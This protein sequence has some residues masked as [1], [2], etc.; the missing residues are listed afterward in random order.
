MNEQILREFSELTPDRILDCIEKTIQRPMTGLTYPMP[1]Y[2]NR[3][4]E[5]QTRAGERIIAKFYRPGRWASAAI[6]DEHRFVLD[7][8]AAEIPVV[9][10]MTFPDGATLAEMDGFRFAVFPK[11]SGREF[12]VKED[13]DWVRIGRLVARLHLAGSLRKAETRIRLHPEF[14]MVADVAYLMES[15]AVAP[16]HLSAFKEVADRLLKLSEAGFKSVESIRIHGD[17]HRA[18]LLE[19]PGEG[20]MVI[21]FDDMAMGPP[22]QDIWLLLP[23]HA[24]HCGREIDLI[25]SGYTQ[26]RDFDRSTLGL[27]EVLRAMRIIYYLAWCGRQRQDFQFRHTFPD[28]GSDRFWEHEIADL[29]KQLLNAERG[30]RKGT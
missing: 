30:I 18:N 8:A 28:W 14:S 11:K 3:V 5:L 25:L 4:Y 13:T 23:E 9:A 27:I 1:S 10:P 20:L 2:I 26:F 19:R 6:A 24:E 15:G 16:R 7:C 21:D 29:K 17:C 22:V 12:E